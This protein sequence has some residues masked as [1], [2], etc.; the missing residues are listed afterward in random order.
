MPPI[1]EYINIT[2]CNVRTK[3]LYSQLCFQQHVVVRMAVLLS[4]PSFLPYGII[5]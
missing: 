3:I 5:E 1:S 2:F 4:P